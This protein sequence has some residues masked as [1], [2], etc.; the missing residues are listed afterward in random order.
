M[1]WIIELIEYA[2]ICGLLIWLIKILSINN[3]VFQ[4]KLI[5]CTV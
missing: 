5:W 3:R 1:P 2:Q 4:W